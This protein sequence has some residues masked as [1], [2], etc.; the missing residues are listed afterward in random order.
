MLF[1]CECV[2][3]YPWRLDKGRRFPGAGVR[4]AYAPPDVGEGNW[5]PGLWKDSGHAQLLSQLFRPPSLFPCPQL[6]NSFVLLQI[7]GKM[8][9]ALRALHGICCGFVI[10]GHC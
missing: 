4:D 2:H 8:L 9:P 7:S 5:T 6:P 1:A 10:S 3:S